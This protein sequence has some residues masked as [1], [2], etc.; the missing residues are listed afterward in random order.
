MTLE[1]IHKILASAGYGSRRACEKFV[2]EGRVSVDGETIRV[3]GTK[4]DPETNEIRVDGERIK[5]ERHKYYVLNK[6]AGFIC[7]AKDEIG[8]DRKLA[9]DLI[10]DDARLFCVGRLD[11]DSEGLLI[12]TN[13]GEFANLMTHPRYHVEKKY[14]IRVKGVVSNEDL[15]G[16]K[17][18]LWTSEGKLKL[19]KAKIV[20][21]E[22]SFT[23]IEAVISEGK[24]RQV[25]RILSKVGYAVKM[26][27]RIGVG[28]VRLG[29]IPSGGYRVLTKGEVDKLRSA[30]VKIKVAPS[31]QQTKK[32]VSKVKKPRRS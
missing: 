4:A 2:E 22:K 19:D 15:A 29:N 1:R 16:M 10:D 20:D 6:P 11:F 31:N 7:T 27:R 17:E 30:A 3:L 5:V 8:R 12:V 9:T 18:G 25:R 32:T 21:R 14:Q 28:S 13:D 26:L 24:N 23:T